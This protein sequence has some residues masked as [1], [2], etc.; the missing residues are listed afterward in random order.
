MADPVTKFLAKVTAKER[1]LLS[2]ILVK[3]LN[4][5]LSGLTAKK[6]IGSKDI[7][8]VRKGVFRI[9]YRKTSTDCRIISVERRS[10]KTYRDF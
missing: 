10:E 7:F 1:V 5:R 9:V 8:R 6:L 4:N 3:I 2:D